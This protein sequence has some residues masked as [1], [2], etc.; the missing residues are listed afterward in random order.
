MYLS[1][2]VY[3]SK[4]YEESLEVLPLVLTSWLPHRNKELSLPQPQN[5]LFSLLKNA[6]HDFSTKAPAE[7]L[8]SFLSHEWELFLHLNHVVKP[9]AG[10]LSCSLSNS[11]HCVT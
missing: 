6:V 4:L 8:L 11:S 7:P 5:Y 2:P 1:A 3:V 10:L 9:F